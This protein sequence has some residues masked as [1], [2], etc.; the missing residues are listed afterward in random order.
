MN[1][2]DIGFSEMTKFSLVF[3]PFDRDRDI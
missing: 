2:K 3:I 1:I